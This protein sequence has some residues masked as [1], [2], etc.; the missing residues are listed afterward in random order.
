VLGPPIPLICLFF[1]VSHRRWWERDETA[2]QSSSF[3]MAETTS[4]DSSLFSDSLGAVRDRGREQLF[5]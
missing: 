2:N 4:T 3:T 1:P 5:W